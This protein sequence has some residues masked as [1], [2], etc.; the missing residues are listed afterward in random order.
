MK[1]AEAYQSFRLSPQQNLT[2][3]LL[4]RDRHPYRAECAVLVEGEVKPDLLSR[5][6]CNLVRR[7]WILR[8]RFL[9]PP[10]STVPVQVIDQRLEPQIDGCLNLS[11]L[12]EQERQFRIGALRSEIVERP[13][14]LCNEHIVRAKTAQLSANIHLM[15]LALPALCCDGAGM[16]NIVREI[17]AHCAGNHAGGQ[18]DEAIQYVDVAQ[19]LNQ[20]LHAEGREAG[21]EYWREQGRAVNRSGLPVDSRDHPFAPGQRTLSISGDLIK[22]LVSEG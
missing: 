4:Q 7:H 12:T 13:F 3:M 11:D 1:Q 22:K 5:A 21:R 15:V 14:D 8:S 18:E 9:N 6:I 2:W 16:H 10:E 17:A 20:V 19:W